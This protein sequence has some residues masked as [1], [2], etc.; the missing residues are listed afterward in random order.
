MAD[1]IAA[2]SLL[3]TR[4]RSIA[5][6]PV[7]PLKGRSISMSAGVYPDREKLTH[8]RIELYDAPFLTAQ[9]LETVDGLYQFLAARMQIPG[10]RRKALVVH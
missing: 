2:A 7:Q 4:G 6:P 9:Q 3:L 5:N 1:V 10:R 8:P